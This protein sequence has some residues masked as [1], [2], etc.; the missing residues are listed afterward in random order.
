VPKGVPIT[1]RS[2]FNLICWHQQAYELTPAD[3]ATQIAGPAFDAAL[4]EIWPYLAAGA[5][6]HIPDERTRL[7]A[8]LLVRWLAERRITLGFLPTPLAEAALR[9]RWPEASRLRVLLTGGDKLGVP[10]ARALPFRLVNHY[11]PTE[12]TVVSTCA[13]VPTKGIPP[14][15]RPLPNTQAYV[16]DRYLQPVPIG[17]PGELLVGGVQLSPGYWKRADLT[18]ERF[19]Q[20]FGK[21]LYRTGDLARWLPDGNIEFLGRI[22]DQVKI[23]GFRIELGEIESVIARQPG[24]REAVVLARD[25][26]G[27][28]RLVA[29]VVANV[30]LEELRTMLRATLPA[31]MVPAHFVRLSRM[32]LTPNGKLDR[33]ALPAPERIAAPAEFVAPSTPTEQAL[34]ELW[35]RVLRIERIGAKDNFFESGGHS[36]LAMQLVGGVRERFGVEL[37]IKTLFERP[38]LAD[39]AGAIDA[40]SWLQRSKAAPVH[41]TEREETLL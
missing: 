32:P 35:Q 6:V 17:V 36:L 9:E 37:T 31:Y 11:G 24:V 41:A 20:A 27:D 30:D 16:V 1:H 29:Y 34:A 8:G 22:D 21:R 3:R 28:K 25:V 2:L 40:L 12:N 26:G 10:P 5:S 14:I 23:R 19:I 38:M 33:K 13:D 18:A 39:L 4:W 7:D 15:G